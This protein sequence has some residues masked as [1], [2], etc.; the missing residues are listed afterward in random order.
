MP[1][2]LIHDPAAAPAT[3]SRLDGLYLYGGI[4]IAMMLGLLVAAAWWSSM[5]RRRRAADHDARE[6]VRLARPVVGQDAWAESADR[7][8]TPSAK[9]LEKQFRPEGSGGPGE[10]G[11][12]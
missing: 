4:G 8:R 9:D 7:A 6:H 12:P 1:V 3:K 11:T 10:G 5:R 2:G